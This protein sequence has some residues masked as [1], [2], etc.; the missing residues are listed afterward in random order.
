MSD[1]FESQVLAALGMLGDRMEQMQSHMEQMH[2]EQRRL[3]SILERV[4][5]KVDRVAAELNLVRPRLTA[6][7]Q[8]AAGRDVRTATAHA[9]IDDQEVRLSLIERRLELRDT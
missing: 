2:G 4:E 7:E 1:G 9:R 5:G 3:T 6:V 8:D